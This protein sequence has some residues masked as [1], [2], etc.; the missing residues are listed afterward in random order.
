MRDE[1]QGVVKLD[2][3]PEWAKAK[4]AEW[5]AHLPQEEMGMEETQ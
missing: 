4:Q 3:L 1:I 2:L 5:S